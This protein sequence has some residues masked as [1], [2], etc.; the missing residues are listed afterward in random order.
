[1]RDV[2]IMLL[3]ETRSVM[4]AMTYYACGRGVSAAFWRKSKTEEHKE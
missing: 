3:V 1:M 2:S 4:Y